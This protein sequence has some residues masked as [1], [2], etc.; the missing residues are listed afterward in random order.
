MQSPSA[1][2]GFA[3]NQ[4][5]LSAKIIAHGAYLWNQTQLKSSAHDSGHI[6]GFHKTITGNDPVKPVTEGLKC[7]SI[8]F[9]YGGNVF[10]LNRQKDDL[11]MKH[12]IVLE[13]MKQG[14]RREIRG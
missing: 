8:A 13:V 7:Q 3:G 4:Q 14:W 5:C 12:L 9:E 6:G 1:H 10:R 11:F 2:F